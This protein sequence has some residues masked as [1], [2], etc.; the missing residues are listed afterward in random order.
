M[1]IIFFNA[2]AKT[3]HGNTLTS[4]SMF[5]GFG[6]PKPIM[7]LK[8]SSESDLA[9]L[10]VKGLN[11]SRFR[12]IRFF[13]STVNRFG[14]ATSC[15]SRW[16]V[17]TD[18]TKH[19]CFSSHQIQLIQI[20]LGGRSLTGTDRND[21]VSRL[22]ACDFLNMTIRLLFSHSSVVQLIAID[23]RLPWICNTA[24]WCVVN[25]LYAPPNPM[26]GFPCGRL[27][28]RTRAGGPPLGIGREGVRLG[29]VMEVWW[30]EEYPELRPSSPP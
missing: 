12:R 27:V 24:L 7:T 30:A 10:T 28:V 13:S 14:A 15:S 19:S 25:G 11:P 3:F 9:L 23:S 2:G 26:A 6:F 16:M 20:L 8:K 4:F 21:A 18:V 5:R 29:R 22:P 1:E 17:S